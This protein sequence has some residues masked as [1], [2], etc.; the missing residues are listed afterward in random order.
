MPSS[1]AAAIANTDNILVLSYGYLVFRNKIIP[2]DINGEFRTAGNDMIGSAKGTT[3]PMMLVVPSEPSVSVDAVADEAQV[4]HFHD[5]AGYL[6]FLVL[7]HDYVAFGHHPQKSGHAADCLCKFNYFCDAAKMKHHL[8]YITAFLILLLHMAG[9][10]CAHAQFTG[11][12]DTD[13]HSVR[14]SII[15]DFRYKYDDYL[16][17]APAALMVGMKAGGYE[18]RSSWGRMLVSDAFSVAIMTATVNGL[19]YTVS[20]PRPDGSRNNSFPSGHTATAFTT[21]TLL[22]K[23]YG[24]RNP[25]FSI[26]GYTAAAV[27]GFSRIMNNKHWMTDVVAGAA[28]GIGSVHLGYFIGD[29][30][31]RDNG[32]YEMFTDPSHA[33]DPYQK[34]YVAELFFGRRFIIGAEGMKEMGVLPLRGGIVGLSTDIPIKPGLGVTARA[35]ASSMTYYSGTISP[36]YSLTAGGYWNFH[37]ARIMEFQLRAM[38]GG[39]W[40]ENPSQS[41]AANFGT[42]LSGGIALSIITDSNFKIKGFVD[43]E[44]VNLSPDRPWI[45][46]LIVGWSSA[47]FW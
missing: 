26:G 39:A 42:D 13:I 29:K 15:P 46:T 24:W 7:V 12:F 11:S 9:P 30:I 33:Y 31:F 36:M 44:S 18:S 40:M 2:Y 37:F 45:N 17:Y 43:L 4:V 14:N 47:W 19:K 5:L 22:H 1:R 28:I 21:A 27:T 23:E 20:R 10:E 34:H 16:Q 32:L 35:S 38:A 25:W 3:K 41:H 6:I 8:T